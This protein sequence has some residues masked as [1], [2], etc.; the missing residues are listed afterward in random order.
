[1]NANAM[2]INVLFPAI[3]GALLAAVG[4]PFTT[5]QYWVLFLVALTWSWASRKRGAE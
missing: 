1:M 3:F 5:W 2:T 4:F